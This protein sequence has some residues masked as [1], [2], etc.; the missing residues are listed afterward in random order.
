MSEAVT[1]TRHA[2]MRS[3]QRGIRRETMAVLMDYGVW[4]VNHGAEVVLMDQ[5]GRRKAREAM[6][7]EAYARIERALDAYLVVGEDGCV[8]TCAHRRGKLRF[9]H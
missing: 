2:E 4:K 5:A 8:V 9:T 3:N 7:R 1:L 6:G